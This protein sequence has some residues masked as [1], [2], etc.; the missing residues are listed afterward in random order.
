MADEYIKKQ[1]AVM[2]AMDYGGSGNAQDA[3]Q[4]IASAL[5]AIPAADVAFVV[6]GRWTEEGFCSNCGCYMPT[7]DAH[8]A[9]FKDEV[10]YC[11]YCGA[12]MEA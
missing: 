3:S 6:R 2:T 4:D 7:D 12:K 1:D 8:D 5:M 11:Y 10:H 9:I